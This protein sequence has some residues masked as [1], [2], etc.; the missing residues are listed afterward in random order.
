MINHY[1]SAVAVN[2]LV[3]QDILSMH[4]LTECSD[5]WDGHSV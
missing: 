5:D 2:L 3:S 1:Y 4:L